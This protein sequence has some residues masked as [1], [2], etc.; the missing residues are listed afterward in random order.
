MIITF[1]GHASVPYDNKIKEL[2]KTQ[3]RNNIMNCESVVCYLGGY[4]NFDEICAQACRELR[5]EYS[6]IQVVYVTPYITLSEQE[7]IKT[8]QLDF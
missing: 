5:Q 4:G 3:I 8:F 2:V 7:K 6:C 1:A